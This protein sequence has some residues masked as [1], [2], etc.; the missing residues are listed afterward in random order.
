MNQQFSE[1]NIELIQQYIA[2]SLSSPEKAKFET[3]LAQDKDLQKLVSDYRLMKEGFELS[4]LQNKRNRLKNIKALSEESI[5]VEQAEATVRKMRSISF[6]RVLSY[7]AMLIPG[8]LL[9]WLFFSNPKG[10]NQ[11]NQGNYGGDIK[12]AVVLY[13]DSATLLKV[14]QVP[15]EDANAL[16]TSVD[17]GQ[18]NLII[19]EMDTSQ[20]IYSFE[21]QTL[22]VIVNK[23]SIEI[24]NLGEANIQVILEKLTTPNLE[25]ALLKINQQIIQ[26]PLANEDFNAIYQ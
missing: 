7:A 25:V 20:I 22:E 1:E 11:N 4:E 18:I 14:F 3:Q 17:T 16:V 24:D 10:N 6:Q 19:S 5:E 9:G 26:I 15:P 8:L 13:D 12:D 2:G 23:Q 21:N